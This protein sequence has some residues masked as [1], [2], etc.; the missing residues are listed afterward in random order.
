MVGILVELGLLTGAKF[1]PMFDRRYEFF[2]GFT[3]F[4]L[5]Y[6]GNDGKD[7]MFQMP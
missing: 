1:R 2:G 6:L 4:P 3:H 5:H 7:A